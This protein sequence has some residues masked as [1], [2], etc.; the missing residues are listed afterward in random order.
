MDRRF[1]GEPN[2]RENNDA[3]ILMK[4]IYSL[5]EKDVSMKLKLKAVAFLLVMICI[6]GSAIPV[7]ADDKVMGGMTEMHDPTLIKVG[8]TWYA[9][10]TGL[11]ENGMRLIKSTDNMATWSRMVNLFVTPLSWWGN[12]VPD[13]EPNQWAPHITYYG[14]RYWVYYSVSKFGSRVSMIGLVSTTNIE[15]GPWRDDG[16]VINSVGSSAFNAIDPSVTYDANGKPWLTFGSFDNGINLVKLDPATMKPTGSLYNIASGNP[17]EGN[18]LT[19]HDGYYYLFASRGYCCQGVNSSY[20]MIYGR[21]TSITG[22]Y[23]DKN[24]IN[25]KNYGGSVLDAGDDRYLSPGGQDLYNNNLMVYHTYDANNNGRPTMRINDVYWDSK[26]WPTFHA[27]HSSNLALYKPVTVSSSIEGYN[28]HIN[29]VNDGQRSSLDSSMGW[30]SHSNLNSNHTEWITV[31]TGAVKTISKVNLFTRTDD[32]GAGFPIDFT[33]KVS[34]NN[35]NWTTVTTKTGYPKPGKGAQSFGFT[36]QSARYV[37]VTG[38]NLRQLPND[39]NYYRM[40]FAEIEIY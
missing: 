6:I 3:R 5:R 2:D 14:G 28:W 27:T 4:V 39:N 29:R 32:V 34:S 16:H 30:S 10:G 13:H 24:G 1:I 35:V 7:S 26:G 36:P 18:N 21:S 31:D 9:A 22:P 12:Y 40:Q 17:L 33:I 23:L 8:N 11:N 15:T 37:K 20:R 19:F 38:T 25:M